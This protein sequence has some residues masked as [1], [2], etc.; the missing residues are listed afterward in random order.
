MDKGSFSAELWNG[1]GSGSSHAFLATTHS[2]SR[3]CLSLVDLI[4]F[5]CCAL[6]A[7][8][9]P[10]NFKYI[11]NNP[12]TD[13]MRSALIIAT[14]TLTVLTAPVPEPEIQSP[15]QYERGIGRSGTGKI[16]ITSRDIQDDEEEEEALFEAR[17][18]RGSNQRDVEEEEEEE[19]ETR[20][21][22]GYSR[23]SDEDYEEMD[24][25]AVRG[26]D[27]R[28]VR[29]SDRR[30]D[31]DNEKFES[32]AVRGSNK[33]AVRGPTN[34]NDEEIDARAVR[35]S[36]KRAV[37]GS[38]KREAE[39]AVRGSSKR[40]AEAEPAVRGSDK[41]E[42]AVRG[43]DKRTDEFEAAVRGSNKREAEAAV[44]GS[45]KRSTWA[46]GLIEALKAR[47]FTSAVLMNTLP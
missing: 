30:S 35:S 7:N 25:R 3:L 22:R 47:G 44:R 46:N 12:S 19:F 2:A 36:N 10:R 14:F 20:A 29:G 15:A 33:R 26:S 31:E 34:E 9:S 6:F 27:K 18:V 16:I 28:A 32:R 45:N 11:K 13:N 23:R 24:A 17:A 8:Q 5:T 42:P 40:E 39:A 4:T 41:R 38:N 43:S 21:V 1:R 37:R